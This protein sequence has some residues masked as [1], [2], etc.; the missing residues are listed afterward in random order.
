MVWLILSQMQFGGFKKNSHPSLFM[1]LPRVAPLKIRGNHVT[2]LQSDLSCPHSL[3]PSRN[4]PKLL[5]VLT[6]TQH[7]CNIFHASNDFL[8]M[9]LTKSCSSMIFIQQSQ[10]F[11]HKHVCKR[12]Q[13]NFFFFFQIF[14]N[15]CDPTILE[16]Y[17]KLSFCWTFQSLFH[18]LQVTWE[19]INQ[20]RN[21]RFIQCRFC[22]FACDEIMKPSSLRLI[23]KTKKL[24]PGKERQLIKTFLISICLVLAM[25]LI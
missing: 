15:L 20:R 11:G 7:L 17:T 9:S 4:F 5:Y 19:E 25:V 16:I 23:I 13:F 3:K 18:K 12:I 21:C 6:R 10:T 24:A 8:D 2:H 14:C 22:L 1:F